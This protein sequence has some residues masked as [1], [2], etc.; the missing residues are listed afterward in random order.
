VCVR[1]GDC[2]VGVYLEPVQNAP[3]AYRRGTRQ[4]VSYRVRRQGQP[5]EGELRRLM[6]WALDRGGRGLELRDPPAP[7][8][9]VGAD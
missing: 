9:L 4:A 1:S 5:A 7:W 2:E 6:D 8:W 3:R